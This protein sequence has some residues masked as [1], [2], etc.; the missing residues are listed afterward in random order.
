[1]V[2]VSRPADSERFN[3]SVAFYLCNRRVYTSDKPQPFSDKIT[4]GKAARIQEAP[5]LHPESM[6]EALHRPQL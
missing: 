4:V 3:I 5:E 6:L 2:K 1:M